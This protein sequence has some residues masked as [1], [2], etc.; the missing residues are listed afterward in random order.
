MDLCSLDG[1]SDDVVEI[2]V[3]LYCLGLGE[4]LRQDSP[5]SRRASTVNPYA[6]VWG[7]Q[8]VHPSL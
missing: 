7:L 2:A 4:F 8:D 3:T 1:L 6:Q 5:R